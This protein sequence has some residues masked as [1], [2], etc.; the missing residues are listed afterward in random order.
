[1]SDNLNLFSN[2]ENELTFQLTIE[3]TTTDGSI[4]KP[5]MR[6]Q[7]EDVDNGMSYSFP[8]IAENKEEV[9]VVIPPMERLI[10]EN[11]NYR[12]KLEVIIGNRYFVPTEVD[13][14]FKKALRVES[15][16]V[17]VQSKSRPRSPV[18]ENSG[19]S[20]TAKVAN[21]KERLS[22]RQLE[23]RRQMK[24]EEAKKRKAIKEARIKKQAVQKV[25]LAK[26]SLKDMLADALE[27]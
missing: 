24:F 18:S 16:T 27:D 23:I 20:V 12:G 4:D 8:V 21:S 25:R 11:K 13:V 14:E 6:F 19:P 10:S 17:Q 9:S 2:E 3:G 5:I 7:I 1:M 26:S 22:S 15:K